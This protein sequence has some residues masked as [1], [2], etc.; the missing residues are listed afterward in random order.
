[1]ER[2][3]GRAYQY[4]LSH[5][6]RVIFSKPGCDHVIPL[7]YSAFKNTVQI[8]LSLWSSE[9]L[10]FIALGYLPAFYPGMSLLL[11]EAI[12]SPTNV[13]SHLLN[14]SSGWAPSCFAD[15]TVLVLIFWPRFSRKDLH[16][17]SD[18]QLGH[19]PNWSALLDS[20]KAEMAAVILPVLRSSFH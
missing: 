19:S 16:G 20:S 15:T 11:L 3:Q 12:F 5:F 2:V 14:P 7:L 6:N 13:C 9:H 18:C 1:M 10:S 4:Y 8:A 17:T